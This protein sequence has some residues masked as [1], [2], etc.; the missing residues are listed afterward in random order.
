MPAK[1]IHKEMFPLYGGKFLLRKAV[2]NWVKKPGKHFSYD[3][4]V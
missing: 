3:E 1:D 4:E 2:H